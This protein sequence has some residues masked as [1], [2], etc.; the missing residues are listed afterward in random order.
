MEG[1]YPLP[2]PTDDRRFTVG[3]I[4]N[5]SDALGRAGFPA[6]T[7]LDLARL[8]SALFAFIYEPPPPM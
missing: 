2:R 4:L 6:M 7:G 8:Q 3:L 5:V 1:N